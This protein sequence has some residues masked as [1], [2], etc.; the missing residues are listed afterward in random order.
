MQVENL[1][2]RSNHIDFLPAVGAIGGVLAL[3]LVDGPD[4]VDPVD[5]RMF[6]SEGGAGADAPLQAF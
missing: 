6:P 5:L 2:L 1:L 3:V 4:P